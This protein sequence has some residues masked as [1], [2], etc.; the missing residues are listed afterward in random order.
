MKMHCEY[1]VTL[2][3]LVVQGGFCELCVSIGAPSPKLSS[4]PYTYAKVQNQAE[5]EAVWSSTSG[6][7]SSLTLPHGTGECGVSELQAALSRDLHIP[8]LTGSRKGKCGVSHSVSSLAVF[9]FLGHP[10]EH[11]TRLTKWILTKR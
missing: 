9:S 8:E 3:G 10:T 1:C 2:P 6:Q 7:E 4:P 5:L 11:L